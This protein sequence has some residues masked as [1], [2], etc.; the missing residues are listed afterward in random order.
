MG[1]I[2]RSIDGIFGSSDP[3][4]GERREAQSVAKEA[5]ERDRI[6]QIQQQEARVQQQAFAQV[7]QG[8]M[9]GTGPSLAQNQLQQ[10]TDRTTSQ[11]AGFAASL[12]GANPALAQRTAQ[13]AQAQANQQAASDSAIIKAQ[14]QL[15]AQNQFGNLMSGIRAQDLGNSQMQTNTD[16]NQ[17]QGITNMRLQQE[18]QDNNMLSGLAQGIASAASAASDENN[19]TNIKSG[20]KELKGFVDSLSAKNYEY[21]EN[22]KNDPLAGKGEFVSVM[23]QDLEKTKVGKSMVKDTP[24]GKVVDYGKGLG[25]MLAS[26][27]ALNDRLSSIEKALKAKKKKGK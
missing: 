24:D 9:A 16:Q 14:E 23:A 4:K 21:K 25:T 2:K 26:Q 6:A 7:L 1:A 15:S 10:A 27:A 18:Q 19:K 22:M 8:Q 3:G 5:R 11:A 13:M 20:D 12:R 17:R